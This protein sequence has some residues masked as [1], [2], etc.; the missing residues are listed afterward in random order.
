M[1]VIVIEQAGE[2]LDPLAK[3]LEAA[4]CRV[5]TRLFD[6]SALERALEICE[7]DVIALDFD[8]PDPALLEVVGH[9]GQVRGKT[10]VAFVERVDPVALAVA[11]R[12]G[13]PGYVVRGSDADRLRDELAVAKARFDADRTLREE[14]VAA[15]TSLSERK[16]IERA[17]GRLMQIEGLDEPSA[18][19][20]LRGLAVRRNRR[21]I[22]VAE[23]IL[24]HIEA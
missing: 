1:N 8:D 22:D 6:A 12:V 7:S 3:R 24:E 21:L 19:R 15:R 18:Y 14:L 23:A 5:V 16:V 4:G 13:I 20:M 9:L 10:I 17:K 11:V 2:R